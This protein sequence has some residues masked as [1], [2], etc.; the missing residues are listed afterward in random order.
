[1]DELTW[2]DSDT[3]V[4]VSG[5]LRGTGKHAAGILDMLA[6]RKPDAEQKSDEVAAQ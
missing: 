5:K 1:M 2:T 4:S 6:R 3:T